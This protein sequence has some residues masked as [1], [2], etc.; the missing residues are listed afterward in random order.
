MIATV[1]VILGLWPRWTLPITWVAFQVVQAQCI[2][3]WH[4]DRIVTTG[5]VL[6]W[7]GAGEH[8]PLW[9]RRER[10]KPVPLYVS[11]AFFLW[12]VWIYQTS[13][14]AKIA[15]PMWRSG[16]ACWLAF[17]VPPYNLHLPAF[18]GEALGALFVLLSYGSLLYE[19]LFWLVIF[20]K[21]RRWIVLVGT[22]F[23]LSIGA[24]TP[25][26]TMS[27]GMAALVL[28]F[29]P[30]GEP[31]QQEPAPGRR[32]DYAILGWLVIGHFLL[33]PVEVEKFLGPERRLPSPLYQLTE[34]NRR[35][36]GVV[37]HFLWTSSVF[38]L[39]APIVRLELVDAAGE[40]IRHLRSHTL[41][42][43]A[44]YKGRQ[45]KYFT[46]FQ[47]LF[48]ES[49]AE[50]VERY[51]RSQLRADNAFPARVKVYELNVWLDV[52]TIDWEQLR[53]VR[54]LDW[55]ERGTLIFDDLNSQP[56]FRPVG[57]SRKAG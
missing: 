4:F 51:A 49:E 9:A 34:A 54:Q 52:R 3:P 57:D 19:A 47:R 44:E 12:L 28:M 21:L 11:A 13:L 36:L 43:Q 5:M 15:D 45:W 17:T 42:A 8:N 40:P 50:V 31:A 48:P 35:W 22:I 33:L 37:P 53:K 6:F 20:P 18:S 1:A 30:W 38:D 14:V 10:T 7:L 16:T 46:F 25:L 56:E 55:K 41:Q 27:L 2:E 23:H 24:F 39:K 32:F 29:C 26:P